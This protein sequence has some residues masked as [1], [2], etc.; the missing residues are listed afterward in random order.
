MNEEG[1]ELEALKNV[2]DA[3][4]TKTL[5]C[6]VSPPLKNRKMIMI[7][8]V[9]CFLIIA[10]FSHSDIH[11]TPN[12]GQ[13]VF[14]TKAANTSGARCLDGSPGLYY[15]SNESETITI[16][17][18]KYFIYFQGGGWCSGYTEAQGIGFDSCFDRR[19][20]GEMGSTLND[21]TIMNMNQTFGM[22][23]NRIKNPTFWNW[24]HVYVRYCD[25]GSFSGNRND[26]ILIENQKMYFRGKRIIDALID[27]LNENNQLLSK[28]T[29]IVISGGSAGGLTIVLHSNYIVQNINIID[30]PKETAK[31][32]NVSNINIAALVNVGYFIKY[33]GHY[34]TISNYSVGMQWIFNNINA[35]ASIVSAYDSGLQ[36]SET[37]LNSDNA[38]TDCDASSSDCMFAQ[39]IA[40]HIDIPVFIFNSQYDAWQINNILG[41]ANNATLINQFGQNFTRILKVHY[42]DE[43]TSGNFAAYINSCCYHDG[44]TNRYWYGLNIN[45]QTPAEAFDQFYR[46]VK[47]GRLGQRESKASFF[48][49]QNDTYPCSNCCPR[50]EPQYCHY[51]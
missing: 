3:K 43:N 44:D 33:N 46:S 14:L 35:S 5:Y 29:D 9:F 7:I 27:S 26:A 6:R 19:N 40:G 24:T 17:R 51:Y 30:I 45:N 15:I 34:P 48:W 16:E 41:N 22:D 37:R 28:A 12:I 18:N 2:G 13:S 32:M 36:L 20:S 21:A 39:N 23:R 31:K 47:K 50:T 8:S 42:L 25:G 38:T 10:T 11:D 4:S 49:F 1:C